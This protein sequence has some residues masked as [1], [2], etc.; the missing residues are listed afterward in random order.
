[1]DCQ[2]GMLRDI[3]RS[4]PVLKQECGVMY[5]GRFAQIVKLGDDDRLGLVDILVNRKR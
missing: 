1:M 2:V 4:V 5:M 3:D